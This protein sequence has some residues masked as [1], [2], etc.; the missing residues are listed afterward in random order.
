LLILQLKQV[1][2]KE[3]LLKMEVES[4]FFILLLIF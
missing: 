3:A 1:L 2:K 4:K